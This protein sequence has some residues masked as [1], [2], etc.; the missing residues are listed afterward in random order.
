[1]EVYDISKMKFD[2]KSS[3]LKLDSDII[4]CEAK[5]SIVPVKNGWKKDIELLKRFYVTSGTFFGNKLITINHLLD[6]KD[7]V[8]ESHIVLPNKLAVIGSEVVGYTMDY[9]KSDNLKTLLADGMVPIEDKINYLKQIGGILR[10]LKQIRKYSGEKEFFL[11]DL[12][13]CNFVVEQGS[14]K[15]YAVDLDSAKIA[16]NITFGSNYLSCFSPAHHVKKYKHVKDG[17]CGGVIVPSENTDLFC[18]IV[19]I[20]NFLYNDRITRLDIDAYYNYLDYLNELGLN[21]ELLD[22]FSRIYD[23]APNLNPD[24]LLDSIKDVYPDSLLPRSLRKKS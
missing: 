22:I 10:E 3:E 9:I 21:K 8:G 17:R 18:Y 20:L 2:R 7:S 15:V 5:L 24:Y 19:V 14:K 11:N 16:G 4:S 6:L 12:H 1:M 23:N 13:E